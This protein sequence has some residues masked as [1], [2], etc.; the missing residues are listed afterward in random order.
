MKAFVFNPGSHR[1]MTGWMEELICHSS[2]KTLAGTLSGSARRKL[3][4]TD[5]NTR[6]IH[7]HGSTYLCVVGAA[8]G[9]KDG[10]KGSITEFFLHQ[11]SIHSTAVDVC[12]FS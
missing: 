6:Q 12:F 7:S 1:E 10:S 11:V 9:M 3:D 5:R 8:N 4:I 2:G